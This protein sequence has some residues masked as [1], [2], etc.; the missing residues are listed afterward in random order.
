MQSS[1]KGLS[2]KEWTLICNEC[3]KEFVT[4]KRWKKNNFTSTGRVYC[5]KECSKEY[6]RKISSRTMA[7]TNKKYASDRMKKNNPMSKPE[8]REKMRL[9]L[10]EIGHSPKKRGGNGRGQTVPQAML[11][12][13]LGWDYEYVIKTGSLK[14]KYN[15]PYHYKIDI[16]NPKFKIAI[17]VD[18]NSHG[19]LKRIEQD[20]RKEAFL[21]EIGWKVIRFKNQEILDDLK[22][23]IKRVKNEL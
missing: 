15:A 17:E 14:E 9:S 10:I 22:G 1:C 13:A 20:K 11:S 12:S 16:A 23:C 4:S 18:G 2:M 21:K 3:G 8:I 7:K 5:S 19:A 6:C